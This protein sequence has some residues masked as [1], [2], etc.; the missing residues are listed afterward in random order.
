[1]IAGRAVA[2]TLAG[3]LLIVVALA[4]GTVPLLVPG[5]AFAV[6]GLVTPPVVWLQSRGVAVRRELERRDVLENERFVSTVTVTA[7]P[8]GLAGAQLLDSLGTE[9]LDVRL[10]P[11]PRGRRERHI[12]VSARFPR[13]GRKRLPAPDLHVS[14]PLGLAGVTRRGS[15]DATVLV[16]PRVEPV[17]WRAGGG[18]GRGR[19]P[20]EGTVMDSV[21]ASEI[22]GL[23]PYRPGTPASRIHWA[24]LARGAGLLER[25]LRAE[26]ESRPMVILD[27]RCDPAE[28]QL[29]DAAVRAAASL[30][31]ELARDGGCGLLTADTARP[32]NV[33]SR[34]GGWSVAHSR[35]ALVAAAQRAPVVGARVAAGTV[36][37]VAAR[38]SARPPQALRDRGGILVMP[39]SVSPEGRWPVAL[40]VAGCVG[41]VLAG[42]SMRA[43]AAAAAGVPGG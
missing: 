21:A 8:L 43:R 9:P 22:E 12:I 19:A 2:V 32:L 30:V 6:I 20:D 23:R 38:A 26:Q 29:L 27:S 39:A 15:G 34:L 16:L 41:Y 36:F 31:F 24:A 40:E 14:D 11:S 28:P 17:S 4:F 7:G 13:R 1:M 42:R 35:L 3:A 37:Y 33:E 18:S 5:F 25:R 10:A